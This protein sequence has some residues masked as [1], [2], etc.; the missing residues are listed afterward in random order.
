MK[1]KILYIILM[2][3]AFLGRGEMVWAQDYYLIYNDDDKDIEV[4]TSSSSAVPQYYTLDGPGG[5]LSFE[6]KEN[7]STGSGKITVQ[8]MKGNETLSG[9]KEYTA[10][11]TYQKAEISVPEHTTSIV[12][13]ATKYLKKFIRNVKV[14]RATTLSATPTSISLGDVQLGET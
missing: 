3:T 8:F 1:Q 9:G 14:T 11:T 2:I 6:Y 7:M 4:M 10:S 12:I 5:T 13:S